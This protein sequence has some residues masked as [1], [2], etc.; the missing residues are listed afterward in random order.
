MAII[1]ENGSV[2]PGAESYA[3]IADCDKY[4]SDRLNAAWAGTD[5][6]K[7][8]AL[9]RATQYIESRYGRR[10]KGVRTSPGQSLGWPRY[11]AQRPENEYAVG[12]GTVGLY[13]DSKSIPKELLM[14]TCECAVRF[15]SGEMQPD[16]KR[17]GS[18]KS[19]TVGPINQV[20]MDNAATTT[21][22]PQVELLLAP[23]IGAGGFSLSRS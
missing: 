6:V 7:E 18:V 9:R 10:W 17:G 16:L 21:T 5:P 11:S 15:L 1:V 4:H 20:F 22:Y 2:V 19:V 3:S 23:L 12:F 8:A 14:A 13:Y